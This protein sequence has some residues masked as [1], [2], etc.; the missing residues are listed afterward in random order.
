LILYISK[1]F[2]V[3]RPLLTET[4]IK[5]ILYSVI[6]E[7]GR[8]RIQAE[9]TTSIESSEKYIDIIMR[10]S[11]A[12]LHSQSTYESDE[13]TASLF[14]ALLHFMLT[15]CTLP[16]ER[17]IQLKNDLVFDIII[18]SLQNLKNNPDKSIVL[19]IIRHDRELKKISQIESLQPNYENIWLISA[20]PLSTPKYRTYSIV[21]A[22]SR[23]Y[24]NIIIDIDN[25]LKEKGDK[26]F[27][28]VH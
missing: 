1:W 16:S 3:N 7:I 8:H 20:K 5:N 27:R 4:E 28:F 26:S 13:I 25:F 12:I 23:K 18:P 17:K 11:N 14:E 19:Q 9:I 6:E 21:N 2:I 24:S 22:G 15:I 10:K